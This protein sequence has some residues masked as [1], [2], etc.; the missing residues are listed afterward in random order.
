ME[1]QA[2]MADGTVLFAST[3]EDLRKQIIEWQEGRK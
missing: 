1:F 3:Y 2:I